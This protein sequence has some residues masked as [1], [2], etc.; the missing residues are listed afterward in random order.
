MQRF[1]HP[2]SHAR[3]IDIDTEEA[4]AVRPREQRQ[5]EREVR[6]ARA[7]Q[8]LEDHTTDP[9]VGAMGFRE[10]HG[11]KLLGAVMTAM[12]ALVVITQVGC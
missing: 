6:A 1:K 7:V 2:T 4:P 12:F 11:L 10:R 5:L 3:I 9:E 8:A